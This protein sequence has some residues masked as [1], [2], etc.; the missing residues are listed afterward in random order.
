[1]SENRAETLQNCRLAPARKGTAHFSLV[2]VRLPAM[3][4]KNLVAIDATCLILLG[5]GRP[6]RK[7]RLI[8]T[9]EGLVSDSWGIGHFF[10]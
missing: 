2:L 4:C 9:L 6:K 5:V 1:V 3:R 7:S 8:T 10:K